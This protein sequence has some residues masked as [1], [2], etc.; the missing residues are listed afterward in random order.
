[1]LIGLPDVDYV[2]NSV[3]KSV[4]RSSSDDWLWITIPQSRM[5]IVF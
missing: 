4:L 1:M 2:Y 3:Y 5:E